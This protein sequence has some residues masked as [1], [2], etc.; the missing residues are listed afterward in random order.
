MRTSSRSRLAGAFTLLA[1]VAGLS[2]GAL[3]PLGSSSRAAARADLSIVKS[4]TP[5]PVGAGDALA[6]LLTVIN[7]GPDAASSVVVTVTLPAGLSGVTAS[8]SGWSCPDPVAGMLTCTR[9]RLDVAEAPAILVTGI[10]PAGGRLSAAASV[11]SDTPDPA[12]D[13][14]TGAEDT[15]VMPGGGSADLSIAN[16]DS[17][18]PVNAGSNISYTLTI[19]N[20]G[21]DEA[22]NVTVTD[23]LPPTLLA[24]SGFGDGWTC[25][26][27]AS[28]AITCTRASLPVGEA[29]AITILGTTPGAGPITNTAAVS[30]SPADPVP[31]N[32]SASAGTTIQPVADLS[33]EVTAAP[34]PVTAGGTLT[35][36]ITITN[37]GPSTATLA[38]IDNSLT[39][40]LKDVTISGDGWSCGFSGGSRYSCGRHDLPVGPAPP[41]TLTGTAPAGG[42]LANTATV[43]VTSP[44]HD[45]NS[46]NDTQYVQTSIATIADLSLLMSDAPDPVTPGALVTYALAV[47]NNGPS[48]ALS[49]VVTDTLPALLTN[50]V[51]SGSGWSCPAPVSQV[52]TCT[53]VFLPPGAAPVITITGTAPASGPLAHSASVSSSTADPSSANNSDTETTTVIDA[54][55]LADLSITGSDDSDP[56]EAG[57][58]IT[59]TLDVAN[60]GP[61]TAAHVIVTDTLAPGVAQPRASGDGW[62]CRSTVTTVVCQRASLGAGS[63]APTITITA[64]APVAAQQILN[65]ADVASDAADPILQDNSFVEDTVV[66]PVHDIA[67]LKIKAPARATLGGSVASGAGRV[68]VQI[69]NRS[70]HDETILDAAMLA[71]LVHVTA[72]SLGDCPDVQGTVLGGTPQAR[73]PATL[74]PKQKLSVWF[75]VAFSTECVNDPAKSSARDPGHEDYQLLVTVDHAALDGQ[76]DTHPA[77]D[78]CPRSVT[79]PF[80]VDP[81]PDGSIKDKGCGKLKGDKTFGDPI[82]TDVWVRN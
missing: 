25:D 12:T 43:R 38:G 6:Y 40:G 2:Y 11:S 74:H 50:V 13:N 17:P 42:S 18:D 59:W 19:T 4:D 30:A 28:G 53:R 82:K 10:A 47:T 75:E 1:L 81:Y 49:V 15:V 8:G 29:P 33:L 32:N 3:R 36:T 78:A 48:N 64:I 37:N 62:S 55:S 60:A 63:A 41:I 7:A 61:A 26:P 58:P 21:P 57:Q 68:Q 27:P 44:T 71:S 39:G 14:N 20:A 65:E 72:D 76:P 34:D 46:A 24:P 73:L 52:L 23:T 35:Y 45:Y 70:P 66:S 31:G 67:V 9:A 51:G 16:A 80:Q 5:D 54:G 56:V 77:D 69:Q 79:A 22:V